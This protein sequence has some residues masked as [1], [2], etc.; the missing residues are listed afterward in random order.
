[1]HKHF[2]VYR[3]GTRE[4]LYT[5]RQQMVLRYLAQ[6]YTDI[7]IAEKLHM[8]LVTLRSNALKSIRNVTNIRYLEDLMLYAR[9]K[10]YGES[11]AS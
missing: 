8:K 7:D 9:D 1:M 4:N 10:G 3:L 11:E 6:G 5:E 2:R